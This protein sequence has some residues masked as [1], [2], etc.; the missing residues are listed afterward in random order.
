MET[1]PL[2]PSLSDMIEL[3]LDLISPPCRAFLFAKALGIPFEFK[4]VD[5]NAGNLTAAH[6][7]Q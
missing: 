6:F 1:K 7:L 2:Q 4:Y 5:L 3:Y